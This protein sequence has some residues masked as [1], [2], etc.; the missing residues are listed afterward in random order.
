MQCVLLRSLI[1]FLFRMHFRFLLR[2]FLGQFFCLFN[3]LFDVANHVEGTL[4]QVIVFTVEDG[5]ETGDGLFERHKLASLTSEHFGNLEGL[6]KETLDLTCSRH[7]QLVLFGQLVHTQDGNN[8]LK[9][10]VILKREN[11]FELVQYQRD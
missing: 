11:V 7:G 6:G 8:I 9:G 3:D 5:L 1:Y 2:C 4:G 10:F